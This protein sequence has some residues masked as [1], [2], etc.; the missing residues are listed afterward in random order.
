MADSRL[1]ATWAGVR[2]EPGF[3]RRS[4]GTCF[5][6][7]GADVMFTVRYKPV[8][9]ELNNGYGNV[10]VGFAPCTVATVHAV[11]YFV[12]MLIGLIGAC[13]PML[14]PIH[15]FRPE[16]YARDPAAKPVNHRIHNL[17]LREFV[18]LV[19]QPREE[20]ERQL[21][22]QQARRQRSFTALLRTRFLGSKMPLPSP[23]PSLSSGTGA[24]VLRE[25]S[26]GHLPQPRMNAATEDRDSDGQCVSEDDIASLWLSYDEGESLGNFHRAYP[27]GCEAKRRYYDQFYVEPRSWVTLLLHHWLDLFGTLDVPPNSSSNEASRC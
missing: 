12:S 26:A 3:E 14:R 9:L 22:P 24:I 1:Q 10:D 27:S 11:L 19:V 16:L 25:C 5:D 4:P 18:P 20:P 23:W 17:L 13:N 15:V 2:I 21:Q 6:L 7:F 8:L